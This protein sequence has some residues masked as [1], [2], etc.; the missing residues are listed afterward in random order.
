MPSVHFVL[1]QFE[2]TVT[3]DTSGSIYSESIP[4]LDVSATAIFEVSLQDMKDMFKYQTDSNDVIDLSS[5]DLK[6]YVDQS[7]WPDFN[8]AN[9]MMDHADSLTPIAAN[10]SD[11]NPLASDK[12]L[13]AHDFTRYLALKLFNTHFG[14]DLFNNEFELLNSLRRACD[15]S[16]A[17]HTLKDIKDKITAVDINNATHA[18]IAGS[19]GGYYMTNDT[20]TSDNLCRVLMT[21]MLAND[22]ARFSTIDDSGDAQSLPFAEGDSISFKLIINAAEGQEELTGVDP[23]GAR[24]YRV[25]YILKETPANTEVAA[26]ET[27]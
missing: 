3:L 22:V 10:G 25:K 2:S 20:T 15:D 14:V 16:A 21:Q 23:I 19:S 27:A 11:G 13:V 12:Q 8:P 6:Y 26:D 4:A 18:D 7:K 17:G 5:S 1:D 24:S 9:A